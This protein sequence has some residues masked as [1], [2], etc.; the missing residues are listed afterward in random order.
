M[1]FPRSFPLSG[2]VRTALRITA[3]KN[4]LNAEELPQFTRDFVYDT[5]DNVAIALRVTVSHNGMSSVTIKAVASVIRTVNFTIKPLA[6][7]GI[8]VNSADPTT[9]GIQP[10]LG[11]KWP[12]RHAGGAGVENAEASLTLRAHCCTKGELAND[13]EDAMVQK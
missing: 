11:V 1:A 13:A 8:F 3:A 9:S 10:D 6:G 7:N 2:P 12:S 4:S 5:N